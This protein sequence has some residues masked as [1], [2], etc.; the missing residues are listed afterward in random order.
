VLYAS[1]HSEEKVDQN[2]TLSMLN[3]SEILAILQIPVPVID[4]KK[5]AFVEALCT[6]F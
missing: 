5:L 6:T 3:G 4:Q 1:S 2:Q